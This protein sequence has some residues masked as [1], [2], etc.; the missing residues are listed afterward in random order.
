MENLQSRKKLL[1]DE[2]NYSTIEREGLA[3]IFAIQEF[4]MYMSGKEF[5]LCTEHRP[6]FYIQKCR[7]ENTRIMR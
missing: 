2:R 1:A 6:L 7:Q 4:K 3:L 5:I